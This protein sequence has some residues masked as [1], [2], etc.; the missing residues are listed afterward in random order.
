MREEI[1]GFSDREILKNIVERERSKNMKVDG[2]D[3]EIL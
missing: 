2:V 1:G 3:K